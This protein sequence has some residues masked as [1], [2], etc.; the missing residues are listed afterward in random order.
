MTTKTKSFGLFTISL[1]IISL[2]ILLATFWDSFGL[3]TNKI[4]LAISVTVAFGISIAG[5]VLGLIEINYNKAKKT[6]IGLIGN[7]LIIIF[8]GLMI[9]YSLN[10]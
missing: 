1:I 7:V 2:T 4:P 3:G 6:R 9:L 5:L 10:R 8:F